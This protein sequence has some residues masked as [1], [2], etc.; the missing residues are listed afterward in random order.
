M[1]EIARRYW[2]VSFRRIALLAATLLTLSGVANAIPAGAS[3]RGGEA[4]HASLAQY[5]NRPGDQ[6]VVVP[7]GLYRGAPS[8][9]ARPQTHGR[10]HGWLVLQAQ[11]QGGVTVDL[12]HAALRLGKNAS[13]LLF[14]G[15]R[16]V[17]GSVAISGNNIAVLVHGPYVPGR[18][19]GR[20][21]P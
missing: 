15:F 2:G 4:A 14:V 12:S 20:A 11:S 8:N 16:F 9:V 10:Y 17:N 7:N 6:L 5:L 1:P 18:G 19:L 3:V 13:R 21:G